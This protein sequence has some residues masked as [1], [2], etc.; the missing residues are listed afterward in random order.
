MITGKCFFYQFLILFLNY[1]NKIQ[2]LPFILENI[3]ILFLI[4]YSCFNISQLNTKIVY[5]LIF[6]T[7]GYGI[8]YAYAGGFLNAGTSLRYSIQIKYILFVYLLTLNFRSLKKHIKKYKSKLLKTSI[9]Y[10]DN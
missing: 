9:N 2:F 7:L 3:L 4:F 10:T 1:I 8:V 5:T 6:F